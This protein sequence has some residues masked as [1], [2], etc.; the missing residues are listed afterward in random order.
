MFINEF[1]NNPVGQTIINIIIIIFTFTVKREYRRDKQ[2]S[3][4]R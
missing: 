3:R 2:H 1:N 4:N